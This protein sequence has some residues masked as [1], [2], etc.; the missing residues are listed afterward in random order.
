MKAGFN[1]QQINSESKY[2]IQFETDN[3]VLYRLV[4]KACQRAVDSSN[5]VN[6]CMKRGVPIDHDVMKLFRGDAS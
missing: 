4:E 5:I 6:D 1:A 3:W 2:C